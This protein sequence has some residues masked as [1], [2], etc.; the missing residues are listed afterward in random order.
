VNKNYLYFL[1]KTKNS[2]IQNFCFVR[3]DK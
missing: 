3:F 1:R 2:E